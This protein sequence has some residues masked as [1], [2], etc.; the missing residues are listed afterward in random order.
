M[1][2]RTRMLILTYMRSKRIS[3]STREIATAVK[4]SKD[5]VHQQLLKL[6][7]DGI[8]KGERLADRTVRWFLRERE[9]A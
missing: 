1:I 2:P 4:R 7:Q 5:G 6:E 3:C 8:I 9:A